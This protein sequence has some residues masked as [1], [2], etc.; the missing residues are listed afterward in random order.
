ML[1]LS[2][3]QFF[4]ATFSNFWLKFWQKKNKKTFSH[5]KSS[6]LPVTL[7]GSNAAIYNDAYSPIFERGHC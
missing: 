7:S 6:G 1:E 3:H 2:T 4:C 5:L